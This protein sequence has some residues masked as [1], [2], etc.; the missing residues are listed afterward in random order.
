MTISVQ[1]FADKYNG[2][3]IDFDKAYGAQ[4]VD[5]FN[6]YNQEVV[7]GGWFGTPVTGGARDLYEVDSKTRAES[8]KKL[9]ADSP[10]QVGDVL[11]YGAPHG[12]YVEMGYK[13]SSAMLISI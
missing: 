13:N 5:L 1:Q 2:K 6:F 8:Y 10:L 4:C 9:A 11:I 7:G 12:R 3:S